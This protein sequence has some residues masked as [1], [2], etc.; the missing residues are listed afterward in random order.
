MEH[1]LKPESSRNRVEKSK[2]AETS[3]DANI[4]VIC[5]ICVANVPE[6]CLE[7]HV[8]SHIS[9]ENLSGVPISPKAVG[10]LVLDE[11]CLPERCMHFR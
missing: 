6:A 10:F 9:L 3:P 4:D 7:S 2:D 8:K 5:A 11:T 1:N